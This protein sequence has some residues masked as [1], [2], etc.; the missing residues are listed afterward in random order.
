MRLIA[1]TIHHGKIEIDV[2]LLMMNRKS[3]EIVTR[4]DKSIVV[5][6]PKNSTLETIESKI[7]KRSRG[8]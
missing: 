1:S 6:A 2:E 3:L 7:K 8:A 4:T 5:K